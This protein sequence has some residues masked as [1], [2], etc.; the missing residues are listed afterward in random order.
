MRPWVCH[1][2]SLS[3]FLSLQGGDKSN[4][5]PPG[6]R[7][8]L[9]ELMFMKYSI[10][11]SVSTVV[12]PI[13]NWILNVFPV[14]LKTVSEV[15]IPH[16]CS[17]PWSSNPMI[18]T[19]V[20]S[21]NQDFSLQTHLQ[22]SEALSKQKSFPNRKHWFWHSNKFKKIHHLEHWLTSMLLISSKYRRSRTLVNAYW[23]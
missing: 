13:I 9:N 18:R 17:G 12:L 1:F 8:R 6:G 16:P 22:Q 23:K 15:L 2:I 21:T 7:E 10:L 4:Y 3:L 11:S 20:T 19:W 5:L 14:L